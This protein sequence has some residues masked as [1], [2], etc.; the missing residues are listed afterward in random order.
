MCVSSIA[1]LSLVGASGRAGAQ[2]AAPLTPR[3][4]SD[5][6]HL[7]ERLWV[8]SREVIDARES[9]GLAAAEVTRAGKYPNPRIDFTW[10]TIPI[11]PTT[12]PDLQDPIGNIPNYNVGLSEL[13]EVAK[14]GPRQ[15]ATAAELEAARAAAL[16]TLGTQ[17][18][19]VLDAI[20]RIAEQQVRGTVID[21]QVR[22]SG[23]LLDLD[24]A[25]AGKGEIA[26]IDVER[27]A[28]E[29][30]RWVAARAA[31]RAALERARADCAALLATDCPP[32][33]S[34]KAARQFLR[35]RAGD[36]LPVGWS[37]EVERQRPDLAALD[38]ALSAARERARLARRETIPDVT[39]RFGYTYDTFVVAGN[40]RQSFNLGVELPLPVLDQG[41]A[42]LAAAAATIARVADT[43]ASLAGSARL[44]LESATRERQLVA[45]RI[46]HLTAALAKAR[47][48]RDS[49]EGAARVGGASQVDVLLARRTYQ[50]L[51]LDRT[52]LDAEA[53]A[54]ALKVRQAA[55]VF[56]RPEGASRATGREEHS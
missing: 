55:A 12:P 7:A 49:M 6:G 23:R 26:A 18:F 29:Q 56:P 53:Y 32:F 27:S 8:R 30:A 40:Q 39:L 11:G 31:A 14:R 9:V 13:I 54:A 2:A 51:L 46:E 34:G 36:D 5:D 19:A 35:A 48:L 50:E 22:A 43:R 24:R 28:V 41:Q 3:D 16:S 15:A 25:R 44:A 17:F 37:A 45:Q 42:D 38:A 1:A 47:T 4:Y 20:G 10:G 33:A 21:G 52:D